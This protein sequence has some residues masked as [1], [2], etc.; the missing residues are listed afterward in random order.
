MATE[1]C[2]WCVKVKVKGEGRRVK[3]RVRTSRPTTQRMTI[4]YGNT[5]ANFVLSQKCSAI[6]ALACKEAPL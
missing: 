3:V 5:N 4:E 6:I 2:V 1:T